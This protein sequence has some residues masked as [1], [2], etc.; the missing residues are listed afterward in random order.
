MPP[1]N[2]KD[3]FKHEREEK[4]ATRTEDGIMDLKKEVELLWLTCLHNLANAEDCG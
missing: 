1:V 4:S 3:L 2:G